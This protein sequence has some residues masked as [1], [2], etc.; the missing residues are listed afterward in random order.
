MCLPLWLR[1]RRFVNLQAE[2]NPKLNQTMS[3]LQ[4]SLMSIDFATNNCLAL[5][6]SAMH[7]EMN[8]YIS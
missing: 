6:R 7:L 1:G 5:Q 2:S 8:E 4:R 3:W